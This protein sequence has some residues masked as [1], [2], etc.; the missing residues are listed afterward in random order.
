MAHISGRALAVQV[1]KRSVLLMK[2]ALL[3]ALSL[4]PAFACTCL[5]HPVRT[6]RKNSDI[7]FRGTIVELR[8]TV[9]STT[10]N[11]ALDMGKTVVFKVSRVW[12]GKVG[13][14][15]EMH[16]WAETSGCVGFN[17]NYLV[18]G[19]ELLV[20]ASGKAGQYST[21]IC[22]DHMLT[23]DAAKDLAELGP[24]REPRPAR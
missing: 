16:A 17:E 18:V 11:L 21:D 13:T 9:K 5:S 2:V 6:K 23:N 8:G 14:T 15:V 7:I 1:Q 10:P 20:Y 12:K 22:G 24:G 4:A 19:N 3:A